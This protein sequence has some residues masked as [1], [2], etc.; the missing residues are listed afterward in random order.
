MVVNDT[1][2]YLWGRSFGRHKLIVLS[3]SK[4]V[5]GYVLG[6]ASNVALT[7]LV[8]RGVQMLYKQEQS[9]LMT[10]AAY[11]ISVWTAVVGPMGGFLGSLVKRS[12]DIKDFGHVLPGHGGLIDRCDCQIL[13]GVLVWLVIKVFGI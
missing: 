6:G 3:P 4:T 12:L 2:A 8:L 11:A 9:K 10:V 5:E 1:F 13:A 7:S